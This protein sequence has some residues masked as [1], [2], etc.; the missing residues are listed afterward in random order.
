MRNGDIG[1]L[2]AVVLT[3]LLS[4]AP[5]QAAAPPA[6]AVKTMDA[7][8]PL[9]PLETLPAREWRTRTAPAACGVSLPLPGGFTSRSSRELTIV[10]RIDDQTNEFG[11]S[12]HMVP[13]SLAVP[14]PPLHA[15]HRWTANSSY[16]WRADP[17]SCYS[18]VGPERRPRVSTPEYEAAAIMDSLRKKLMELHDQ[19]W[20][21]VDCS[22]TSDDRMEMRIRYYPVCLPCFQYNG[23]DNPPNLDFNF[24]MGYS[25]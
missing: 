21:E 5:T 20:F 11:S 6:Y 14:V 10:V 2:A 24:F 19:S 4:V 13:R 25:R 16:C 9:D 1:W 18:L 15:V 17:D 8:G 22:P 3:A 12:C 23:Q 7:G